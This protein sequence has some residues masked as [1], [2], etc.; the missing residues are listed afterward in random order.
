MHRK[1]ER[2]LKKVPLWF[3]RVK[4]LAFLRYPLSRAKQKKYRLKLL[5]SR[6]LKNLKIS[7]IDHKQIPI[8]I[9]VYNQ[10]KFLKQLVKFLEDYGYKNIHFIDNASTYRPLLEYLTK[11]P[12]VVHRMDKNYG[13]KVFTNS[14]YFDDVIKNEYYVLTDPD[15]VPV[16]DCPKDFLLDF[17]NILNTYPDCISKVGCALKIDD[18]SKE[19]EYKK[20][21]E[22]DY[23][24]PDYQLQ[25]PV[26]FEL[27]IAPIDTT[28]A[29]YRPRQNV[30]HT[31]SAIR[32]AGLYTALHL[33]WYAE[34]HDEEIKQYIK[35]SGESSTLADEI[36]GKKMK[37]QSACRRF[38]FQAN[39]SDD[40]Y[41]RIRI[42]RIRVLKIKLKRL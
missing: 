5:Y 20:D 36:K 34:N 18:I 33:P 42:F 22:S 41:L 29:L 39:K 35:T 3:N 10:L 38:V 32:V 19:F 24:N 14:G 6:P 8:Y 11:T 9:I 15:V 27:Y 13:Y 25:S 21:W 31:Y 37:N 30:R 23:W 17:Y 28:F 1:I 16:K 4:V 26:G 12:Y 2:F 40:G 7:P